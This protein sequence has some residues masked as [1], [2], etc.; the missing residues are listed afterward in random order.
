MAK[1]SGGQQQRVWLAV[2][3]CQKTPILLLDE[4]TTYL[5]VKYQIEIL[6]LIKKINHD[7][8]MTIIMVHHD[9]NQAINYSDEIVAMKDGRILFQGKPNDVINPKSLKQLYDYKLE[10]IDHGNQKIV[11]NYQ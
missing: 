8:K 7:Y 1:L 11:L 10:V 4:P 2:A 3:L 9:I 5:D 6:N